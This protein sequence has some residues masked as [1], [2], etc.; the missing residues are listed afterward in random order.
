MQKKRKTQQATAQQRQQLSVLSAQPPANP[1]GCL[2]LF[3]SAAI[4]VLQPLSSLSA[5]GFILLFI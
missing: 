2:S 3:A 1:S 5:A 4:F